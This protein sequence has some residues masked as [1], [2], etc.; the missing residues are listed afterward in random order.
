MVQDRLARLG[1]AMRQ[2]GFEVIALIPGPTLFHLTGL[3][4]HL[5]ERPVVGIFTPS[6]SPCLVLPELERAKAEAAGLALDLIPYSEEEAS[7]TQALRQAAERAGLAGRRIGVEPLRM[8]VFELRLLEAAAPGASFVSA[9]EALSSLRIV[10]DEAEIGAMRRAVQVAEAALAATLPLVRQGMTEREFAS[11]LTLQLL[12][13]GSDPELPFS[14]IIAS[15]PNSALPHALPGSRR[16]Q[17]GDLVVVDWG[18]IVEGYV[19]DLTRTFAVGSVDPQLARVHE[20]VQ[21]ANAA[22]RRAVRPGA[23]CGEV[24]AA[25]RAVIQA[26]GYGEYFIHRTGH[27]IGLESHEPPYIRAD[28]PQALAPGMTFT[29]E[30][31]IY[32]QGRGGV[33]VED[34]MLVTTKRGD[35]LSS[36][37]REM[38]V[39]S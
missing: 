4:F 36:Y 8:R 11:E 14:P 16:L 28:D 20:T 25:A 33:R 29:V 31:G 32:L 21:Q 10:K 9:A 27:G 35:S 12:R 6:A 34:D 24:D 13:A 37:P 2:H 39:I 1:Q 26:A 19:S 5:M 22:G 38:G 15:G 3:S 23:T 30:P 17:A 7:R 18:A